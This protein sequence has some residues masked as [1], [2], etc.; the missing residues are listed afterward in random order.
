[1][2]TVKVTFNRWKLS[3]SRSITWSNWLE[4]FPELETWENRNRLS[5]QTAVWYST[6]DNKNV[7]LRLQYLF[8]LRSGFWNPVTWGTPTFLKLNWDWDKIDLFGMSYFNSEYLTQNVCN[9]IFQL[10]NCLNE[11]HILG[12]CTKFRNNCTC[13]EDIR[14]FPWDIPFFK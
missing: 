13:P 3:L 7:R 8:L 2:L 9:I 4:W 14:T 12:Y 6:H 5:L 10:W 11:F 1:M